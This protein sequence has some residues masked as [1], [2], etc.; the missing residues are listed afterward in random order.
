MPFL[1]SRD[2]LVRLGRTVGQWMSPSRGQ[3]TVL[4]YHDKQNIRNPA[5]S[6]ECR[7]CLRY[8]MVILSSFKTN[9]SLLWLILFNSVTLSNLKIPNFFSSFRM[10]SQFKTSN[11]EQKVK[12]FTTCFDIR[13]MYRVININTSEKKIVCATT[14]SDLSENQ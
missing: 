14:I 8:C 6:Y 7:L 4:D 3:H 12:Y 2:Q 5:I 13:F 9:I 10:A 11:S 1:P